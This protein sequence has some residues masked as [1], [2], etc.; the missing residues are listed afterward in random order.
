MAELAG[1]VA[2][3]VGAASP[4]GQV[5]AQV[6]GEAG[7]FVA[8]SDWSE[9]AV[10]K[11]ARQ[12]VADGGAAKVYPVDASKKLAFQTQLE[13]LLEKQ[14]QIDILVNASAVEPTDAILEMDEWDWRRALDL[15]LGSAFVTM[16]S[17]GRVMRE[18]GGGVMLNLMAPQDGTGAGSHVYASAAAAL[19]ALSA[20]VREELTSHKIRV[21][22]LRLEPRL[23][24]ARAQLLPLCKLDEPS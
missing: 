17:V 14:G 10:E 12:L 9:S 5:A 13:H 20:S 22:A 7:A 1:R 21:H 24:A 19:E 11:L 16:Q 8:L 2:L 15:N 3:V 18:L 6:L 23:D 4:L